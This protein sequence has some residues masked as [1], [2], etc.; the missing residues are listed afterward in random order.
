MACGKK[1]V[2]SL[3]RRQ[4]AMAFPLADTPLREAVASKA[5]YNKVELEVSDGKLSKTEKICAF[6]PE[7]TFR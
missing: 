3:D 5:A 7:M 4:G 1:L 2:L 6:F